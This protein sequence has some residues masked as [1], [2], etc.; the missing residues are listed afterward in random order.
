[1]TYGHFMNAQEML[2]CSEKHPVSRANNG[3]TKKVV[4]AIDG[5]LSET[6]SVK[7]FSTSFDIYYNMV[8][9]IIGSRG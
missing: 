5:Q 6:L 2:K 7:Q 1:M 9:Q 8:N 4:V 3:N